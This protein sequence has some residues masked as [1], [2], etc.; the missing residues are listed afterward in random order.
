[1]STNHNKIGLLYL[2]YNNSFVAVQ[3]LMLSKGGDPYAPLAYFNLIYL[4]ISLVNIMATCALD[5]FPP[6]TNVVGV[7]PDTIPAF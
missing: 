7:I 5:A 6:G 2:I 4:F 1:M 3:L